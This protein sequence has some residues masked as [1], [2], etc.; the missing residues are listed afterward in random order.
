MINSVSPLGFQYV[1]N[2]ALVLNISNIPYID[3]D[4]VINI[5]LSYDPDQPIEPNL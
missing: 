1:S 5:Q 3:D 2:K 4:D